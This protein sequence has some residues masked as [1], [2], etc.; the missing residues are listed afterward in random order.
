MGRKWENTSLS[1]PAGP[2]KVKKKSDSD[3]SRLGNEA[4]RL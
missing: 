4:R 2:S 3:A 1:R